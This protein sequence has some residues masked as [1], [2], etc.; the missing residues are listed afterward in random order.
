MKSLRQGALPQRVGNY[1]VENL[2]GTDKPFS[3]RILVKSTPKLGGSILDSEIA[4]Q[5]T[6]IS[7]RNDLIIENISF[8]LQETGIRNIKIMEIEE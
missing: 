7:F 5:N 8:N 1:A 4:G 2:T 6:M 3:V